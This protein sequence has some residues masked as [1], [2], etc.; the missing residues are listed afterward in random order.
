MGYSLLLHVFGKTGQIYFATKEKI[1]YNEK[2][3][4]WGTH[5]LPLSEKNIKGNQFF[6]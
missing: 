1:I 4:F 3:Q 5:A 6:V 2:W